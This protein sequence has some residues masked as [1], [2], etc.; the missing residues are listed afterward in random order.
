MEGVLVAGEVA[1]HLQSTAEEPLSNV[2][3]PQILRW[4]PV[5]SWHINQRYTQPY[6]LCDSERTEIVKYKKY[7]QIIGRQIRLCIQ[8]LNVNG[9]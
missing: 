2:P 4:E 1:G 3:N 6:P 8:E 9:Q 5:M 7:D